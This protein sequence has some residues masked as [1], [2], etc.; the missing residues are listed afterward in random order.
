MNQPMWG[1]PTQVSE[2][3]SSTEWITSL[4]KHLD[5]CGVAPSL[6]IILVKHSHTTHTFVRFLTTTG[7]LLSA[8]DITTSRERTY[9]PK[10][11]N[12]TALYSSNARRH[13]FLSATFLHCMI[14]LW[15]LFRACHRKIISHRGNC[16]WGRLP[17]SSTTTTSW[18]CRCQKIT[19]MAVRIAARPLHHST[20]QGL[21]SAFSRIDILCFCYILRVVFSA[22]R[23]FVLYLRVYFLYCIFCM[24]NF[25]VIFCAC[26]RFVLYISFLIL[27]LFFCVVFSSCIL[28]VWSFLVELFV[29]YCSCSFVV[30]TPVRAVWPKYEFVEFQPWS[31]NT[32]FLL[33]SPI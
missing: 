16:G 15:I 27:V 32:M 14:C 24:W 30:R 2:P 11:Q 4:K 17:F 10:A 33:L 8:T 31:G 22:Y 6:M 9:T 29:L 5:T 25:C 19:R 12:M 3:K 23:N 13:L 1:V 18:T 7:Q 21:G 20:G 28:R 26:G